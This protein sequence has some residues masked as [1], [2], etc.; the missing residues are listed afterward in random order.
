MGCGPSRPA[1]NPFEDPFA[2]DAE[3]ADFSFATTNKV[4]TPADGLVIAEALKDHESLTSLDL[5]GHH[6]PTLNFGCCGHNLG[7]KGLSAIADALKSNSSLRKLVLS[8][9]A[10]TTGECLHTAAGPA[11]GEA[12]RLNASLIELHLAHCLIQDDGAKIIFENLHTNTTLTLLD[13]RWNRIGHNSAVALGTLLQLNSTGRKIDLSHNF[14]SPPAK[15]LIFRALFNKPYDVKALQTMGE[16]KIGK[17][18]AEESKMDRTEREYVLVQQCG[19]EEENFVAVREVVRTID[20]SY[21]EAE[22]D[23]GAWDCN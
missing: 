19:A 21:N 8:K 5:A 15:E 1:L 10:A 16:S 6:S 7:V 22:R 12:L 13:L 11:L 4:L 3:A 23:G 2:K 14:M 17:E 18:Y 9:N 20:L